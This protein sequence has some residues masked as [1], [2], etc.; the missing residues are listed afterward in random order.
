MFALLAL[1]GCTGA[2]EPAPKPNLKFDQPE[3]SEPQPSPD[4][5]APGEP[6]ADDPFADPDDVPGL[7]PGSVVAVPE[8]TDAQKAEWR[9]TGRSTNVSQPEM[10]PPRISPDQCEDIAD[11]GPLAEGED[12]V[13]AEIKCEESIIGHTAGGVEQ[14]DS[15]FYEKKRCWPRT[16]DH[17]GGGERIY[18][19]EMPE[20]E[21]RAWA[22]K[23][24][25]LRP[26]QTIFL[27]SPD[28]ALAEAAGAEGRP[29]LRFSNGGIPVAL[30]RLSS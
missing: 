12:C 26:N 29:L 6:D 27:L 22:N 14:F 16:R 18:R 30:V 28:Q 2:P 25:A 10:P 1:F 4:S 5:P 19:L 9:K 8:I 23:L 7:A 17:D 24:R 15:R 20:G 11:G 13:T 21:W 3:L